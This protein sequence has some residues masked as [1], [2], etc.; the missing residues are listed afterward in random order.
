MKENLKAKAIL[1]RKEG[2]S[3]S[4]ILKTVPVAKSTLSSW[5]RSVGLARVQKQRLTQKKLLAAKRGAAKRRD[6]RIMLTEQIKAK[7][8]SEISKID[9]TGLWLRRCLEISNDKIIFCIYIH[10]SYKVKSEKVKQYWSHITG[11]SVDKF[12]KIYYKRDKLNT[13]RKN[14]GE[15]YNGLLRIEIVKSTNLNRKITGWIEGICKQ[16]GVV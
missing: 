3:Y 10:E 1:R 2:L 14:I 9:K 6:Q 8:R 11:H 16:C 13:K 5:L 12:G 7:A 15:V 4:E